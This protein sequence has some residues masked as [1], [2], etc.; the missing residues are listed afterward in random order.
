MTTPIK[1]VQDEMREA[2]ERLHALVATATKEDRDFTAEE[3]AEKDALVAK[4]QALDGKRKRGESFADLL[5]S[6][7]GLQAPAPAAAVVMPNGT[8]KPMVQPGPGVK[9]LGAQFVESAVYAQLRS[10]P[11]TGTWS[12]PSVDLDAAVTIDPPGTLIPGGTRIL[13]FLPY[14]AEWGIA[15]LF[16]PGTMDGGMIQYLEETLWTNAAAVVP[17]GGAKPESEKKF[18]L[19]QQGL[20]KIAHWIPVVDEFLEDVAGLRSFIDAQMINGV[21]EKLQNELINGDGTGGDI[22]GLIALPNKTPTIAAGTDP[23]AAVAALAAQRANIFQTSR[24]KPDA[25]VMSPL[26]WA[27]VAGSMTASGGFLAGPNVFAAGVEPRVWGMRVVET[28]EVVDGTAILGAFRMGGQ[29][30]RK[31]GIS[32]QASNAHADFFIKNMTAIRAETR[33]ALA[34]YRPQAF[35]LV[36][37]LPIAALTPPA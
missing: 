11:R 13:P 36:T 35:G 32:V 22:M 24:L 21:V 27:G 29:L 17:P 18:A 2:N 31:G 20:V 26:T 8:G 12:T 3:S 37:G 34:I 16:A 30:F 33:V 1:T 9:S 14:P 6:V 7:G 10:M 5:R 19:R 15:D 4:M 28:Q 25:V 23:G